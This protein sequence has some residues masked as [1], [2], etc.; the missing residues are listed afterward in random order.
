MRN[1]PARTSRRLL[2]AVL[3]V[4]LIGGAVTTGVA[5][6]RPAPTHHRGCH[7]RTLVLSAMPV[8]L[9]P[10]LTKE[11]VNKTVIIDDHAFY[12]GR[13]SG[14][15]VILALTGIGPVNAHHVTKEAVQHFRCAN[16][17]RVIRAIVFS[18]VSGGDF[19]GNV[20]VPTRWTKNA[21]KRFYGVSHGMVR[22][23]RR[24][25]HHHRVPLMQKTGA[26]DPLCACVT[27]PDAVKSVSVT[28]KPRIEIGGKGQT[29]DPFSGEALPCVPGGGDVFGCDPCPRSK[30]LAQESGKSAKGLAKFAK[31][32]FLTGY[33]AASGSETKA[34]VAEDEETAAVDA[35]AHHRHIPFLGFR[36]VSDGGGDPLG[37]PGFPFQ[38]FYYRQIS[39]D[40]AALTTMAFLKAW[41]G[42]R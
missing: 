16:G 8:E 25:K 28:H 21:G 4:A 24:L 5:T 1:G 14:R 37:L 32:S 39:A 7:G 17:R 33:F 20:L 12:K 23:V 40:N 29:T 9:S 41:R 34:Y 31:P 38:F 27:D 6:A 19:I 42:A 2:G 22:A 36:A 15:R 13:L 10:L 18:G 11:K 3:G 30:R 26:G 35:V